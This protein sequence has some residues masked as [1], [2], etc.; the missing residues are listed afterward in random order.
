MTALT[1]T[2]EVTSVRNNLVW[3]QTFAKGIEE[4][5]PEVSSDTLTC[6]TRYRL[7]VDRE[8]FSVDWCQKYIDE[9]LQNAAYLFP[10]LRVESPN[11]RFIAPRGLADLAHSLA[12]TARANAAEQVWRFNETIGD[13][14]IQAAVAGTGRETQWRAFANGSSSIEEGDH[15]TA[16]Q[17]V[18]AACKIQPAVALIHVILQNPR[19]AGPTRTKLEVPEIID[20]IYE[21]LKPSLAAFALRS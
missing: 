3:R 16:F 6:G 14:H 7:A 13:L 19:F 1:A 9:R 17:R 15:L 21:A 8:V 12:R 20:P 10:G 4:G 18:V 2:C 11:L 5:P